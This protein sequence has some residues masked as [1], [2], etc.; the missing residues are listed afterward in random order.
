M[1]GTVPNLH[2]PDDKKGAAL[3][4][5][6]AHKGNVGCMYSFARCLEAGKGIKPNLIEAQNWYLKAAKEGFPPAIDWCRD[7]GVK[8]PDFAPTSPTQ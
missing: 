7:H 8:T 6:G 1:N 4:S 2:T 5:E 3:F